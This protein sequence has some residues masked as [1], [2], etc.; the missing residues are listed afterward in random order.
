MANMNLRM[1]LIAVLA[2]AV[3][4]VVPA[5]L[6]FQLTQALGLGIAL[7]GLNVLTGY[8]GQPSLGHGAF[9]AIGA[10]AAAILVGLGL[11]WWAALPAAAAIGATFAAVLGKPILRLEHTYLALATFAVAL[12]IPQLLRNTA[13]E[14]WTGGAQG[15]QI[16]RPSPPGW[17]PSGVSQ[18]SWMYWVALAAALLVVL[19]MEKLLRGRFGLELRA[20]RDHPVAASASGIDVARSKT[21]AFVLSVACASLGGGLYALNVQLVTPDSFL[22]FLSLT[23]LV[24]LVIGGAGT[25]LGPWIGALFV[26]FV[27]SVADG[28]STAAPWAVF[29]FAVLAVVFLQPQGVAAMLR[30]PRGNL[31]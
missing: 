14:K 30:R 6:T 19:C 7:V 3:P 24:G 9:F 31:S 20:L 26:Q 2:A 29:G 28:I 1:I 27:P 10:Y 8:A 22:V 17:M 11:P 23:M 18:D 13:V 25:S 21:L 5:F 16:E 15:L 12:A 4:F